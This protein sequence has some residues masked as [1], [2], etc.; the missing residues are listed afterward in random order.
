M[1][2]RPTGQTVA[3]ARY[4]ALRKLGRVTGRKTAE[5]LHLYALEGFLARLARS[6]YREALVL[7][8]GLLLAAFDLRRPTRD[9]DLLALRIGNDAPV[10]EHLV[11]TIAALEL[12][13]GLVFGAD[14]VRSE[15]IRE[16]D[17][18]PG[19]RVRLDAVLATARLVLYVDVNVGD[20]IVPAPART[21]LPTLLGDRAIELLAYPRAMVIAEK[22]ATAMQR[23]TANTRW[24][25]FADLHLL[26]H[27]GADVGDV[28][29]ALRVVAKH[30]GVPLVPLS[31]A[32]RGFVPIAEGRWRAWWREQDFK[33]GVPADLAE[34]L[35][36]LLPV[37]DA[38]IA[39]AR[40]EADG[41]R[42]P[43]TT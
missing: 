18:Y 13:D 43:V 10:I 23:A 35:D 28:P 21:A 41:L 15:A 22:L 11:A 4:L 27:T 29:N 3:G 9:V 17:L 33:G 25:D 14:T 2:N 34:V 20:P 36:R 42:G 6:P 16:D 39:R 40:V 8:G 30:R 5:L 26:L 37:A 24:R 1:T 12:D 31:D 19:V 32:L 7:K 38:I